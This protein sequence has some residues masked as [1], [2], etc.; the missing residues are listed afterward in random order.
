M[1]SESPWDNF[2]T[3]VGKVVNENK[4]KVSKKST[5][6]LSDD[7]IRQMDFRSLKKKVKILLEQNKRVPPVE[8]QRV[9]AETKPVEEQSRQ[10]KYEFEKYFSVDK[11]DISG[12]AVTDVTSR[13]LTILTEREDLDEQQR[14]AIEKYC[15]NR[16]SV[17][18]SFK[19]QLC[20][21]M[22]A[23]SV[24]LRN[25]KKD[26]HD[27]SKKYQC[28]D[29]NFE[30][31]SH[32]S[33]H[34]KKKHTKPTKVVKCLQCDKVFQHRGSYNSH[35]DSVHDKNTCSICSKVISGKR[36]LRRHI[37]Q[38]HTDVR[39]YKCDE[40]NQSFGDRGNLKRHEKSKHLKLRDQCPQ[41]EI[42]C[43]VG[44]LQRHIRTFHKMEVYQ[45]QDCSRD[46]RSKYGLSSHV[47]KAH[48]EVPI[49]YVCE[50]CQQ[51]GFFSPQDKS[52]HKTK[53]HKDE[54]R[55]MEKTKFGCFKC[56]EIFSKRLDRDRH[57]KETHKMET[58][59]RSFKCESCPKMFVTEMRLK[60]HQT[61]YCQN[62]A[63]TGSKT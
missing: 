53:F 43:S 51:G 45:C 7:T 28:C 50:I 59:L 27:K 52:I 46:F 8:T 41:C 5:K 33:E 10:Y 58:N 23:S 1:N 32:L 29:I 4:K 6:G 62:L 37:R 42:S 55:K 25:H 22:F 16:K 56:Q 54:K 31:Y 47:N 20:D 11:I 12:R 63:G 9:I 2:L 40:C 38:V 39:P 18:S 49:E 48:R 19:C 36:N 60:T 44:T 13:M 30:T 24:D 35:K 34:N 17:K 61:K 21:R 3:K 57:M 26:V 15:G 14:E